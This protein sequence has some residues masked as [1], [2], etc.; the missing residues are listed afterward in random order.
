MYIFSDDC[1]YI[2]MYY[3]YIWWLYIQNINVCQCALTFFVQDGVRSLESP[4]RLG[5]VPRCP[6]SPID[7][8]IQVLCL[9][10]ELESKPTWLVVTRTWMD[11]FPFHM[12]DVILPIDEL[13]HFSRWERNH[14]PAT[15]ERLLW[16]LMDT[17][18]IWTVIWPDFTTK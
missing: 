3:M 8:Q 7:V 1:L 4:S 5:W 13:H 10:P 17:S 9:T 16:T 14:Q 15:D 2:Y 11:Y 18:K 6:V 12:W